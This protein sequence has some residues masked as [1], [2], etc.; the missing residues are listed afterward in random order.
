[1]LAGTEVQEGG[2]TDCAVLAVSGPGKTPLSLEQ[3]F[4]EEHFGASELGL[5]PSPERFTTR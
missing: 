2:E 1:L 5:R 4:E 3:H